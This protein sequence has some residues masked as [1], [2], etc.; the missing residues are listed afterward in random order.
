MTTNFNPVAKIGVSIPLGI[1]DKRV[2][3]QTLD[4][5]TKIETLTDISTISAIAFAYQCMLGYVRDFQ[6]MY[7]IKTLNNRTVGS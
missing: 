4:I 7:F 3:N 6:K 1:S 5:C 2:A